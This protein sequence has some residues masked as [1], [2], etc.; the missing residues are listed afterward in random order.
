MSNWKIEAAVCN[1]KGNIRQNN[2]DSYYLNGKYMPLQEMDAGGSAESVSAADLQ[3]YSVCD[4]M[5]GESAGEEA[6]LMAVQSIAS[7]QREQGKTVANEAVDEFIGNASAS[8]YRLARSKG[9]RS[10]TTLTLCVWQSGQM[11]AVHVGDSRIYL[12]RGGKLTQLTVDHSEVQRMVN[13]GLITAEEARTHPRRHVINQY[14]GMPS[15]E[16]RVEPSI[17]A[18]I[19]VMEGDRFLLCSDGLTDMVDNPAI[20]TLL[21][22]GDAPIEAAQALMQQ[23]LAN[24]GRDN[25]TVMCV[26][27]RNASAAKGGEGARRIAR[28][29]AQVVGA[30]LCLTGLLL[31]VELLFR[32][33]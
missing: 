4:G 9:S 6:S 5:G 16:V 12:L 2:E 29:A 15:D 1:S 7:F 17:S 10:G 24:G 30:G 28:R 31:L 32:L 27:I 3:L 20:Q 19:P 21:A 8:I 33:L 14:L 18:P 13:M 26:Y 22:K 25:V 23:A 11:R